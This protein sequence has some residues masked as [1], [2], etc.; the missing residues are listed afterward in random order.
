ME[1]GGGGP[2]EEEGGVHLES[3]YDHWKTSYAHWNDK[4]MDMENSTQMWRYDQKTVIKDSWDSQ[5]G[6]IRNLEVL[7]QVTIGGGTNR[8]DLGEG[9]N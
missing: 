9:K 4:I 3:L 8:R 5:G 6:G 1:L 7:T 2:F